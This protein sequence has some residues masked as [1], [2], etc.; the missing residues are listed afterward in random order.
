[1]IT[2][3]FVD[4][5]FAAVPISALLVTLL[6][7]PLVF[8]VGGPDETTLAG[9][10]RSDLTQ[11]IK[12]VS[13]N[14]RLFDLYN[15]SASEQ[16]RQQIFQSIKAMD[17]DVICFQEFFTSK[18]RGL[19]NIKDLKLLL[20]M[21][22]HHAE[23]SIV[24]FTSDHYGLATFSKYPIIEKEVITN[25]AK[26]TNLSMY[27][28]LKIGDDTIRIINCHLQSI[29]FNA[30]DYKFLEDPTGATKTETK[31]GRAAH[32]LRRMKKAY[33]YR[34]E[35][36]N[37][38]AGVVRSS[39][40][41]VMVCGDFND[42][43]LSYTYQTISYRLNDSF[44]HGGSGFGQTYAGPLPGLRIDYILFDDRFTLKHFKTHT[45]RKLSDHHALEAVFTINP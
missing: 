1:V 29:R 40:Y 22:Y 20:G 23:Y 3:L 26:S 30:S 38:I 7:L 34:S 17:P 43:P 37:Q 42:T 18:P 9:E 41:K 2:W 39:P 4:R 36:A 31:L 45:E 5:K 27:S 28:D 32:I 14:V 11:T 21:P 24:K 44:T 35:Q 12:V 6:K 15:W 8:Q 25:S 19:D 33:T 16:T 13:F 10:N